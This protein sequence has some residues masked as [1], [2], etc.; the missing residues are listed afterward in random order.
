[1]LGILGDKREGQITINSSI[2]QKKTFGS[3]LT[4]NQMQ[5]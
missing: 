3:Y 1:M 5:K 2:Q 4:Q